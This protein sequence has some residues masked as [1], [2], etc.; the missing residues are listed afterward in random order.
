MSSRLKKILALLAAPLILLGAY[1]IM[2]LVWKSFGLPT[3][4]QMKT[5][6]TNYFA[7]YGLFI[8]FIGAFLE[9]VLLVG[10]YFPGGFI[11]FFGVIS[12]AG[13]VLRAGE[14]VGIVCI[15]FFIAYYLNYL[16]GK[17]GWYK[18][19][20]RFGLEKAIEDAKAKLIKHELNAILSTYWEPNLSSITAT[21]AGV[22]QIPR[23]RF[24]AHSIIGI[25]I[26]ETF[27][28]TLVFSLG[29]RAFD[30]FGIKFVLFVFM[31][32]TA[33]ILVKHFLFDK[34][35]ISENIIP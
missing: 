27:W 8:V 12:A 14:V 2:F 5:S 32:W 9:G 10:Q 35:G 13:N 22:L 18:L 33:I 1:L 19:L 25:L 26:W 20:V 17:Y 24:L 7:V 28:G 34:R 3:D 4:D 6:I 21:A 30:L 23:R 15:A 11:I 31:M 16:M 29:P